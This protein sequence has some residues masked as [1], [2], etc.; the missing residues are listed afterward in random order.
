VWIVTTRG[1]L[2]DDYELREHRTPVHAWNDYSGRILDLEIDGF[3]HDGE[4]ATEYGRRW[5]ASLSRGIE[6][7]TV[8]IERA[9]T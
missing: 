3:T 2:P 6:R 8:A 9:A 4:E 1:D 7:M 5:T